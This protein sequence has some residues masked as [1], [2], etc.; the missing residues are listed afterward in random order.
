MTYSLGGGRAYLCRFRRAS[1]AQREVWCR[2]IRQTVLADRVKGAK[3]SQ[4]VVK[5]RAASMGLGE[6]VCMDYRLGQ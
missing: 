1:D 4:A 2:L 6:N 5:E 3:Q